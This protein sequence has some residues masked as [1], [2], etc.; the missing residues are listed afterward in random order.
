ML[1][2]SSLVLTS[3]GR[4]PSLG[5][6]M[7]NLVISLDFELFWGVGDPR[8]I[9]GYRNNIEG[10]WEAIPKMLHL[11]QRYGIRATWA[12]VGM[13]MCRNYAQWRE[14]RP[15]VFPGYT[16]TQ[17]STYSL[18]SIVHE[19]PRL[20]FARPLVEQILE[21]PGQE[22]ASHSYSH[23]YCDE[24]GATPEQFAAD[25]ICA[26]V[27]AAEM[28]VDYRSFVF[29]RNQVQNAYL[30]ELDKAG[31]R[32]FRGNPDHW[33]YR[34]GHFVAGGRAARRVRLADAYLPLSGNHVANAS[35]TH[36]MVDLPASLALRPWS[37]RM[38]AF[39][40]LRLMRLKH[41]MTAAAEANGVFHLW[42][43]PHN[44]GVN[45]EENMT[46]LESLLQHYARLR[47]K[48]GMRSA[49]MGD[50]ATGALS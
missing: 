9:S 3:V 45:I 13:L 40:P 44:F 25:L 12:T 46:V 37:R 27:I 29:P 39:E 28:G 1:F 43:H 41:A 23:F 16:L 5:T 20:F 31:Y 42:W 7:S 21:T 30:A 19:N 11:F 24:K 35:G 47:D 8:F 6:N 36:G 50:F 49:Q 2:T 33:L 15:T 38:Q 17:C 26:R 18:D 48:Y 4:N 32:V 22:I 34:D 14:I 10:E